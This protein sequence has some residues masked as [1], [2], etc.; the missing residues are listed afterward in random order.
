MRPWAPSWGRDSAGAARQEVA[1]SAAPALDSNARLAI[2]LPSPRWPAPFLSRRSGLATP[3]GS[4]TGGS[5]DPN[6]PD[7]TGTRLYKTETTT[8]Q[9]IGE[10]RDAAPRRR[11][12]GCLPPE[13][14]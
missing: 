7:I 10:G 4:A 2:K 1:H 5:S 12:R 8:E 9:Y 13:A 14:A 6:N 11:L 3:E